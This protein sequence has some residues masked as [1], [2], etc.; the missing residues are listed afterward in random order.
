MNV[1][2][3]TV[4]E[5]K[6]EI[7]IRRAVGA[8]EQDIIVQFLTESVLLTFTGGLLGLVAGFLSVGFIGEVTGWTMRI[9]PASLLIPFLLAIG[10]GIFSGLYP[11][12]KAAKLD[13][14]LALRAI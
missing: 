12:L 7:G 4:S 10:T 5:R 9:T 13:P 14:I 6:R 11:A 8:T 1:M 3:A 2:L